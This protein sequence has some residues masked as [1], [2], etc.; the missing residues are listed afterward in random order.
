MK[1]IK[2]IALWCGPCGWL[3]GLGRGD[4][5]WSDSGQNYI[6]IHFNFFN[7]NTDIFEYEYEC[8]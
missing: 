4:N 8:G 7:V 1:H 6:Y 5:G 3:D 2:A